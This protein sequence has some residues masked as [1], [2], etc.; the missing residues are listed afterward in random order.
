[1]LKPKENRGN[2]Q[3]VYQKTLEHSLSPAFFAQHKVP[4]TFDGR[5]DMLLLS[6]FI[7]M[8]R[9]I[10]AGENDF[11]Q[12]LFDQTFANMDQTLREM[13]IGD[14]GVP[15]HQKKMMKAFNGRTHA[16]KEGLQSGDLTDALKKNLY[17]TLEDVDD[18]TL[19]NMQSYVL[20]A[21]EHLKMQNAAD[22]K[23]GQIDFLKA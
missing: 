13:G 16:Y 17:G 8:E 23:N 11:N 9:L 4:D 1:M 18:E 10:E 14:M 19:S 15:K 6:L 20:K 2:S 21:L 12:A 7:V 3:E 5:F 22:I